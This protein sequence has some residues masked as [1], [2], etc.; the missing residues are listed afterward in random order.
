MVQNFKGIFIILNFS[1]DIEDVIEEGKDFLTEFL[2]K[3]G[4]NS[5][6]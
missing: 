1:I 2:Q 4:K 5:W 6:K 3:N